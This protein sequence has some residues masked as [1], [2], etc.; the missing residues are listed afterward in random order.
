MCFPL[1]IINLPEDCEIYIVGDL[2]E[3]KSLQSY[4]KT[5]INYLFNHRLWLAED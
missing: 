4:F 5:I 2:T 1:I 3:P